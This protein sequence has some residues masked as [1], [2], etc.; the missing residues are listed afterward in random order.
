MLATKTVPLS[1]PTHSRRGRWHSEYREGGGV[2]PPLSHRSSATLFLQTTSTLH[3]ALRSHTSS[4]SPQ[5]QQRCSVS[6][7]CGRSERTGKQSH[8]ESGTQQC[9]AWQESGHTH[10]ERAPGGGGG[11]ERRGRGEGGTC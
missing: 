11:T 7:G 1:L 3:E 9:E 4:T 10:T 2:S 5:L 6:G 8:G